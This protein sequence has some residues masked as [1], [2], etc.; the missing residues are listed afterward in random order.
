MEEKKMATAIERLPISDIAGSQRQRGLGVL[1]VNRQSQR[2]TLPLA[3]VQIAAR[4][5]DRVASVS[6]SETF[7]NP[8]REHLEAVYIFPLA[9]GAAVSEFEMRVGTRIIKGKVEE[10]GQARQHYQQALEQ[11]KRAALLEQERDDVFTLQLGNLPPSEE[12]TVKLSYSER[13][14]YFE[15]GL[16]ELRLPLVVA[17]R[18]IP[19]TALGRDDVGD[20]VEQDTAIV[21]DASR[22]SPPRLVAGFDPKV[23]LGIDVE[24]LLAEENGG[25]ADLSCSQHATRAAVSSSCVKVELAREDEPL[26]RDFVLQWRLAQESVKPRLLVY[27][28]KEGE[29][30][31]MLSVIP[32]RREGF[33]GVA[34]DVVFVV[35]RSG[36]MEGVKMASA[37]RACSLLLATLGPRDRFAIQA[38]DNIVEWLK[39]TRM[40]GK[41]ELFLAADEA[42]IEKGQQFLN[43]ITARGGTEMH[44]ALGEAIDAIAAR[45]QTSGRVSVIVM[46]TDG[47]VGDESRVL[48]RIQTEIGDARVFTVGIDTAVNDGFLRRL[49]TLGG[50]TA[51]F[52]T[53][54]VQLEEALR[55]VGREIGNP[56]VVNVTVEDI[57]AGLDSTSIAPN[58][59][60]DL[61]A[62]RATTAF[63]RLQGRGL[64]RVKGEWADGTKFSEK[65]K[66][67]E[68]DLP[69]ISQLWA[70][71][72]IADLEDRFRVETT[73][74]ASIRQQII[75]LSIKHTLLT[76]FTAFVVV[77]ESEIVNKDGSHRKLV[78]P[79]EMP[80]RWEMNEQRYLMEEDLDE[81]CFASASVC[82]DLIS[83]LPEPSPSYEQS[84]AE[85]GELLK[86]SFVEYKPAESPLQDR[87]PSQPSPLPN[88]RRDQAVKPA[89][90]PPP[91]PTPTPLPASKAVPGGAALPEDQLGRMEKAAK[92]I[93]REFSKKKRESVSQDALVKA[94]LALTEALK[95]AWAEI[96]AGRVPL[97]NKLEEARNMLLKAINESEYGTELPI[98][99]RFLRASAVELITALQTTGAT[100]VNLRPLFEQHMKIYSEVQTEIAPYIVDQIGLDD[101]NPFWESSI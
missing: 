13:L 46:L 56:L 2:A 54:G 87:F 9:G 85:S 73:T 49:A 65:V 61:F 78:Q 70:K 88:R 99:Q 39:P 76:R 97:A 62:G 94:L 38:F 41:S 40:A 69:A 80:Q 66:A 10:R 11:G 12:V 86:E 55:A 92:K 27:R 52:V 37:A 7:H 75:E 53:P 63:L 58:R 20:G 64:L 51:T 6:V 71:A 45:Q 48:K 47:Q 36:S 26:D 90:A 43:E 24:L 42:G 59:I 101:T 28:N 91:S 22:I 82:M 79:V 15:D 19:G 57:D 98:L 100:V 4:V 23:G 18:Y 21:P 95:D 84:E 72:R 25:I 60:P 77:D 16:T 8:Y 31:G 67:N 96:E 93:S 44:N 34:R 1:S 74:Q 32:P 14:P 30:Y 17:P 3:R 89:A 50:G 5:A 29:A 68:L 35:D 81:E 83:P 33:L